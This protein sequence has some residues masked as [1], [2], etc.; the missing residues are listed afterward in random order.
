MTSRI[1]D[2]YH[3]ETHDPNDIEHIIVCRL[4]SKEQFFQDYLRTWERFQK[5]IQ[6]GGSPDEIKEERSLLTQAFV[7]GANRLASEVDKIVLLFDTLEQ[8]QLDSSV[9]E[10]KI[11]MTNI[12]PRIRGWMLNIL[13][14]ISNVL[15]VFAGRPKERLFG[16]TR[17]SPGALDQ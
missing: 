4:N 12:D 8:I 5:L 1:L 11:G 10:E 2:L 9:V 13:P 7:K 16:E 15:V 6:R 3:T 17:E 14:Q